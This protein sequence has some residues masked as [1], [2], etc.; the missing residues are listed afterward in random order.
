MIPGLQKA[1]S[2]RLELQQ[3]LCNLC[4]HDN[5]SS[6]SEWVY[7]LHLVILSDQHRNSCVHAERVQ[8]LNHVKIHLV[9]GNVVPL[10]GN[11][12]VAV[13]GIYSIQ[14]TQFHWKVIWPLI[15]NDR[16]LLVFVRLKQ[17]V[18]G[19]VCSLRYAGDEENN[20]SYLTN[21]DICN[22]RDKLSIREPCQPNLNAETLNVTHITP[23]LSIILKPNNSLKMSRKTHPMFFQLISVC[24]LVWARGR[25][26]VRG[27]EKKKKSA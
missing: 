6:M 18:Q 4:H 10:M 26:L 16:P 19:T 22:H 7:T 24:C 12:K 1:P 2:F 25:L 14:Y 11:I 21:A 20:Y 3:A 5:A 17:L 13:A 23:H 15:R 27:T 9:T 8:A